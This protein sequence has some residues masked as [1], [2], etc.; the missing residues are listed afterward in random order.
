V[1]R[2]YLFSDHHNDFLKPSHPTFQLHRLE[3]YEVA[4]GWKISRKFAAVSRQICLQNPEQPPYY[5]T[6]PWT[7]T[8]EQWGFLLQGD[9]VGFA[10]HVRGSQFLYCHSDVILGEEILRCPSLLDE[11][12]LTSMSTQGE[13][14]SHSL[15]YYQRVART[16]DVNRK[17]KW[18]RNFMNWRTGFANSIT[19]YVCRVDQYPEFHIA[20]AENFANATPIDYFSLRRMFYKRPGKGPMAVRIRRPVAARM[21]PLYPPLEDETILERFT[22]ERF[23]P[24]IPPEETSQQD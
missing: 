12:V 19:D 18:I 13:Q 17:I 5:S 2:T 23:A 9:A 3:K 15:L 7:V 24:G 21:P 6:K 4:K 22:L 8:D 11:W 20:S 16:A 14:V 1:I 10:Y